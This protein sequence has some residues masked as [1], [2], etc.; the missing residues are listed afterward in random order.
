MKQHKVMNTVWYLLKKEEK[1]NICF[2]NKTNLSYGQERSAVN[3][4][5]QRNKGHKYIMMQHDII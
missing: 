2:I 1:V 3:Q 5:L 4:T